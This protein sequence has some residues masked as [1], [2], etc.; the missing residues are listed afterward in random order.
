[1]QQPLAFIHPN[2]KIHSSVQIGA[3]SVIHDDVE[4]GENTIIENNVTIYE[5][6]R[7]GANCHIFPGAVI[8]TIPQDLKFRGETTYTYI[9]DY[10]NLRECVTVHRGTASKGKTVVGSHCLI[11]A[12]C[13]VAHDCV[14]HDHII[15]SNATQ[16][17]GEV[18]VEDWAVIGGG[19]LVHQFTHIGAHA[20]V[21]GGTKVTKDV[22]PYV[23]AAREPIAY[24]GIN[25]VGLNRRGFTIEQVHTIQEVYRHFG[26]KLNITQ[27]IAQIQEEMPQSAERDTI[28]K[29]IQ[30]SPRGIIKF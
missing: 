2:A 23:I 29:F 20:M 10:T 3:F 14:L 8:G 22:P 21:Q 4:I 17:A 6:T 27:A 11:M 16:L 25:S 9:G 19:S 5:H 15:L 1:M 26:G 13:H 28:V 30:A 24:F 12:Y 7:I 18:E